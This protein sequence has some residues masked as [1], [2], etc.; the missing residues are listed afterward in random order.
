MAWNVCRKC[1]EK[2]APDNYSGNAD[3]ARECHEDECPGS[4]EEGE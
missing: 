1:G 2:F 4:P 3:Y